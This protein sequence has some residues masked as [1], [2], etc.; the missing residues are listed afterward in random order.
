MVLFLDFIL[1]TIERKK[2]VCNMSSYVC[3]RFKNDSN[4]CF[5]GSCIVL[6]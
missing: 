4:I 6:T 1:V 3:F 2:F 5:F